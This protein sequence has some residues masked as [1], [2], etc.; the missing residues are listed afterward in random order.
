MVKP[1]LS[2]IL[3]RDLQP[4]DFEFLTLPSLRHCHRLRKYKRVLSRSIG[5]R[6][7]GNGAVSAN[8]VSNSNTRRLRPGWIAAVVVVIC[9]VIGLTACAQLKRQPKPDSLSFTV[10]SRHP[11]DP[12][13]FT[14]GLVFSNGHLLEGTGKKGESSLRRVEI[15]TGKIEKIAPLNDHYFGEG[16]ALLDHRIYQLTWQNRI[17]L[18]Y[19]EETFEVEKT[20]QYTGEGWGLTTDG[21][22]LI[23]SDGSATIRF[24]DPKT[25]AVVKRV[26]AKSS[27][28]KVSQ[29]NELEYVRN[30]IWANIWYEDRIAR[31]SPETGE[32]LGWIDFSEL[33]PRS[34]RRSSEDVMNGIAYDPE[35]DRVFITGK[36]WPYLY[37]VKLG[38]K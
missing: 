7:V 6:I 3:P 38:S 30:E 9:S 29:L 32:V 10:V 31:I 37:E 23:M 8:H 5:P 35:K 11:H 34:Q 2:S 21:K 26:T 14:Q 19:N 20:F 18:V 24:I 13:A 12:G 22:H 17:G 15:T 4:S 28:G 33:F 1:V 36:N 27:K 25:F 16:I